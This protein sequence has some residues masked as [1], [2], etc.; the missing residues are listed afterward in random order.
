MQIGSLYNLCDFVRYVMLCCVVQA[1]LYNL[2]DTN[3][4][5]NLFDTNKKKLAFIVIL[6]TSCSVKKSKSY[7]VK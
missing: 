5:C 1:V 3:T 6:L 4:L 7:F 2:C